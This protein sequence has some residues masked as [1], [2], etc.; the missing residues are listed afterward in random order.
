MLNPINL[1]HN[2][3]FM[4][5][6]ALKIKVDGNT[7]TCLKQYEIGLNY[8]YKTVLWKVDFG[9]VYNIYNITNLFKTMMGIIANEAYQYR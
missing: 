9:G 2:S 4:R 7:S 3:Y 1:C 5:I 6:N 8:A